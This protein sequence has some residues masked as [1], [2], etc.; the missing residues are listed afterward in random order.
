[1]RDVSI[2][3]LRDGTAAALIGAAITVLAPLRASAQNIVVDWNAIAITAAS[4]AGQN[5]LLQERK[6][7]NSIARQHAPFDWCFSEAYSLEANPRDILPAR[8]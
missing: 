7:A 8:S 1:M 4:A 6:R 5:G 2:E 3:R